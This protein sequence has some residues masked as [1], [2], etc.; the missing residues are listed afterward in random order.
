MDNPDSRLIESL[1]G[2]VRD[3]VQRQVP[4]GPV[5]LIDYPQHENVGDSA[6][7]C[8]ETTALDS[9]RWPI[10]YVADR[11]FHNDGE[12]TRRLGDGTILLHGGGNLGDLWPPHQRFRETI[13]AN[14]GATK[15]VQLPQ[16]V[17]FQ[18]EKAKAAAGAT[19]LRH[20]DLTL[21]ARDQR[22]LEVLRS[23]GL[24]AELV[25]DAAFCLGPLRRPRPRGAGSRVIWLGRTDHESLV[26]ARGH[27][28]ITVKDWLRKPKPPFSEPRE[29][30]L[31][32]MTAVAQRCRQHGHGRLPVSPALSI[33]YDK[34]A[35]RRILRGTHLLSAADVVIT[36]RLHGHILC[37]LL[38]IPH[39]VLPDRF[40]KLSNFWQTWTSGSQLATW[41]DTPEEALETSIRLCGDAGVRQ[42]EGAT[43]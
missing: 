12:M 3:F 42:R 2:K 28:G 23:V 14:H 18:D 29:R 41:C 34:A 25:P 6:I 31:F 36:D 35:Q 26:A 16:T 5:A 19:L 33:C 27:Q 4:E 39:V 15:I 9:S 22:S 32:H 38:G 13:V 24:Q 20:G 10:A 37:L 21:A 30:T 43:S 40:G 17:F 8:G 1:A 11:R 7:W